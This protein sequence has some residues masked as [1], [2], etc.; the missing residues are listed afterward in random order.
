MIEYQAAVAV[1]ATTAGVLTHVDLPAILESIEK[2]H[3]VGPIL[4]PTLYRDKR[5]AMEEDAELLKAALPLWRLAK[6]RI[7]AAKAKEAAGG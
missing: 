3:T 5:K 6:K 1:C 2:A 7:E 4:D